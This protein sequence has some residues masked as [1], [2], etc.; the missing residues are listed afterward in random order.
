MLLFFLFSLGKPHIYHFLLLYIN[1]RFFFRWVLLYQT[2][3]GWKEIQGFV[4]IETIRLK[5]EVYFV[6]WV[7][8]NGNIF[9]YYVDFVRSLLTIFVGA[10]FSI[11]SSWII[12]PSFLIYLISDRTLLEPFFHI[13]HDFFSYAY[14]IVL[15]L[16]L[17]SNVIL[18][19]NAYIIFIFFLER[20]FHL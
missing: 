8:I 20:Y 12:L 7:C 17:S 6:S 13:S 5:F 15:M 19:S 4:S 10:Y 16:I 9:L 1:T 3:S 11:T 2:V 18:S 14:I